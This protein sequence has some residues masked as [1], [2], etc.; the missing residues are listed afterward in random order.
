MRRRSDV[1]RLRSPC[2]SI[3]TDQA[4]VSPAQLTRQKPRRPAVR[5]RN[6]RPEIP[7]P[8]ESLGPVCKYQAHPKHL[9]SIYKKQKAAA[10]K[11]GRKTEKIENQKQIEI[12]QKVVENEIKI[13]QIGLKDDEMTRIFKMLKN[14]ETAYTRNVC[15]FWAQ[16]FD[17][18]CTK[19][20]LHHFKP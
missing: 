3:A 18:F 5:A 9:Y 14:D 15:Q 6:S 2:R 20:A 12:E 8:I 13:A 7:L 19:S 11:K 17:E 10:A 16:N 1:R 4:A